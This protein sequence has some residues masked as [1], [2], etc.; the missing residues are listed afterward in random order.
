M[1]L[2]YTLAENEKS[3]VDERVSARKARFDKISLN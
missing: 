3:I 2:M 1:R